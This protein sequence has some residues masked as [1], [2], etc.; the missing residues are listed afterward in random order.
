M[1]SGQRLQ[2]AYLCCLGFLL[3]NFRLR[4]KPLRR[5]VRFFLSM[6]GLSGDRS[7]V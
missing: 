1:S 2:I 7:L 5:C 4:F 3:F 6:E